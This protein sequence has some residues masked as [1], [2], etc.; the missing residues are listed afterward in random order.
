V[1]ENA[2]RPRQSGGSPAIH[3]SPMS[4]AFVATMQRVRYRV[5][6]IERA[7]EHRAGFLLTEPQ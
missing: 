5:Q 6:Y 1:I 3:L 7:G 2:L 4:V